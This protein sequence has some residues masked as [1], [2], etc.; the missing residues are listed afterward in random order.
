M[1]L[2]NEI[3]YAKYSWTYKLAVH[4][5][6]YLEFCSAECVRTGLREE[7]RCIDALFI[8]LEPFKDAAYSEKTQ[9]TK[10]RSPSIYKP[11]PIGMQHPMWS[12]LV[13]ICTSCM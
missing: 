6:Q 2:I 11:Q 10:R 3:Y 7:G 5:S 8:E 1:R 12:F 9:L 4:V 13:W